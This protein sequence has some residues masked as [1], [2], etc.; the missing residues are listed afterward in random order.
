MKTMR[1][2]SEAPVPAGWFGDLH[3]DIRSMIAV[4]DGKTVF[5]DHLP[6]GQVIRVKLP[7]AVSGGG[8]S[9][10]GNAGYNGYFKITDASEGD[11]FKVK[12]A[13]GATGGA[14]T[15]KVNNKV[16]SV[17]A[18]TSEAITASK[19]VA[20][21]YTAASGEAA[22]TVAVELFDELPD[23]SDAAAYCQIGRVIVSG[24]TRTIQQDHTTGV[25]QIWWY[26][27]CSEVVQ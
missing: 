18:W 9:G 5:V 7:P 19:I 27:L 1:P 13:D 24:E 2:E 20:L 6:T 22:A 21:K 10:G 26:L 25:A 23:D 17:P 11:A 16:F 15:C 8:V 14:S 12:V 3:D 4:G